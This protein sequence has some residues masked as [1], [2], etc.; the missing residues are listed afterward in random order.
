[1]PRRKT[2]QAS[3]DRAAQVVVKSDQP[4]RRLPGADDAYI[5][6]QALLGPNAR[7]TG[8]TRVLNL[9]SWLGRGIDAWVCTTGF[10]L[11]AMLLSGAR[12]TQSVVNYYAHTKY[13]FDYLTKVSQTRA[14]FIP[15]VPSD[16]SPLHVQH[17]IGWL[18][19][20]AQADGWS[21][22]S[23]RGAYKSIKA[24]LVEMFAQGFVSG[25]P[26]RFFRRGAVTWRS[27]ES[28]HTS[29]SD[30]EQDRLAR[31]IKSDLVNVH[32]GRL[33]L[34]QGA[35][36]GLRLLLVAHR[37]GLNPTPLLE[38][39]RDALAPGF[40]PGI[41]R[42]R[43][44]KYRNKKSRSG[45][46]RR[47]QGAQAKQQEN[48]PADEQDLFFDLSEGAVL[49][50]AI[51]STRDL[52]DEAAAALK[53]RIWLYRD[54]SRPTQGRVT[55]LNPSTLDAA[56]TGVIERHDLLGDD[57][58]P[59]RV[60]L[61]RLRKSR[62]D[63]ALRLADGDM[64]VTANLMGNTPRVSGRDYPSMNDARKAE[65]AGFLN[66]DFTALMRP[67]SGSRDPRELRPVKVQPFKAR[68]DH[69]HVAMRTLTS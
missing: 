27:G 63:R 52:V 43:T 29:L 48:K 34:T 54:S 61:S 35:V 64:V 33:T 53:H 51:A 66:E 4:H 69:A 13:L 14:A 22:N 32:H 10:C 12:T 8:T 46:G 57:G 36:Q 39:R 28:R 11:K 41:I 2:Y 58:E 40:L 50:Q 17:F 23:T 38:M 31:A 55:C 21:I 19:K 6:M 56:I 67:E 62:F 16:L 45:V 5:D 60:N 68:K 9:R 44:F 59:L 26:S 15:E 7:F 37:Q 42:I 25:E 47:A 24:V 18:E 49:Q 65:A 30:A 1:M 3:Q 20:L